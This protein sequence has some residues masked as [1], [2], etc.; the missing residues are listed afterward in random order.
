M[1]KSKTTYAS[2]Y[3]NITTNPNVHFRRKATHLALGRWRHVRVATLADD[4]SDVADGTMADVRKR[5][6]TVVGKVA[7]DLP[8]LAEVGRS[9]DEQ[10]RRPERLE[11]HDEMGEVELSLEVELDRDVL[12]PVACLPPTALPVTTEAPH[13]VLDAMA[14][15]VQIRHVLL[16]RVA[17]ET[18]QFLLEM[19]HYAV[20]LRVFQAA[21]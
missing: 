12:F 21:R 20:V 14:V 16:P 15:R 8:R 18:F 17:A 6:L 2:N 7:V 5:L 1:R 13:N 9:L 4:V 10:R 3:F 19:A 11:P